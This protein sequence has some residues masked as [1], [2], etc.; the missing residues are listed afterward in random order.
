MKNKIKK[1][2]KSKA[3]PFCK[4]CL[5][6]NFKERHCGVVVL[7]EGQKMNP[8]TEPEDRCIFE[9]EYREIDPKT[10]TS[11]IWKPQVQEIR[12]WVEPPNNSTNKGAV[13]IEYPSNLFGEDNMN[14]LMKKYDE[15]T[16]SKKSSLDVLPETPA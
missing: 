14:S 3:Q 15:F 11:E 12:M 4:N 5:L 16:S 1:K 13:K 10:G 7:Y 9:Q 6:Y 2:I 8:P